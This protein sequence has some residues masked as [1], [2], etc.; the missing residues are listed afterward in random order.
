M[1]PIHLSGGLLVR[2]F[3]VK[4]NPITINQNGIVYRLDTNHLLVEE[5]VGDQLSEEAIELTEVSFFKT[6]W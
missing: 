6:V 3:D 2:Y 5:L 4:Q 1:I